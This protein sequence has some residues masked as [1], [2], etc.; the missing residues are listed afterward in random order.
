MAEVKY[1]LYVNRVK[2]KIGGLKRPPILPFD[3]AL[4]NKLIKRQKIA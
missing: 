3:N 4:L 2:T 1:G